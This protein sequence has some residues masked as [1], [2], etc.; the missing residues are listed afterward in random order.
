MAS[1]NGAESILQLVDSQGTRDLSR[2]GDVVCCWLLEM[3]QQEPNL[4]LGKR[5]RAAAYS[6]WTLKR[7]G[8]RAFAFAAAL[9]DIAGTR[10]RTRRGDCAA[11][12]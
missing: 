10:T 1:D 2:D 6:I 7:L 9:V 11:R 3:L 12:R 5:Q 4:F 8:R